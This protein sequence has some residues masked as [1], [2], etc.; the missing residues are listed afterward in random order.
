MPRRIQDATPRGRDAKQEEIPCG[1][2]TTQ[3]KVNI[4]DT[5]SVRAEVAIPDADESTSIEQILLNDDD[6][7]SDNIM[8]F[9]PAL[10][11]DTTTT[12]RMENVAAS[13]KTLSVELDK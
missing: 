12:P 1:A 10:S 8:Q 5:G 3:R 11:V 6:E 7:M 13:M 4:P 9:S 2:I